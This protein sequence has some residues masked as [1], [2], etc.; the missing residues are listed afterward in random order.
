MGGAGVLRQEFDEWF[1]GSKFVLTVRKDLASVLDSEMGQKLSGVK[2]ATYQRIFGEELRASDRE[3]HAEGHSL[4]SLVRAYKRIT[5]HPQRQRMAKKFI[6][7]AL[8]WGMLTRRRY[9]VSRSP[10]R[11]VDRIA[12]TVVASSRDLI[13]KQQA[14]R[15]EEGRGSGRQLMHWDMGDDIPWSD[16]NSITRRCASTL[17]TAPTTC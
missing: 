5:D 11:R 1:P 14:P 12:I 8:V 3:A 13:G 16:T 4:D 17:P 6:Q 15:S 2:P 7:D 9:A 10:R